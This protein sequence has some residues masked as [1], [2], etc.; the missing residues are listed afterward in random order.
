MLLIMLPN[1]RKPISITCYGIIT[2]N[3]QYFV[4]VKVQTFLLSTVLLSGFYKLSACQWF[5]A[6]NTLFSFYIQQK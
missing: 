2:L 3:N 6:S 1:G 4:K 5:K